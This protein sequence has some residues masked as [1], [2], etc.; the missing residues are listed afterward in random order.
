M[1]SWS[2]VWLKIADVLTQ[3][4]PF[5]AWKLYIFSVP[6]GIILHSPPDVIAT[7]IETWVQAWERLESKPRVDWSPVVFHHFFGP[8]KVHVPA[9]I[10]GWCH[11][12]ESRSPQPRSKLVLGKPWPWPK[13]GIT[14]VA[15][16]SG[17]GKPWYGT[18]WHHGPV[19]IAMTGCY[20]LRLYGRINRYVI[21]Q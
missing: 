6:R 15:E 10:R 1:S 7:N 17:P 2:C 13:L 3:T 11:P 21:D 16:H 20:P 9:P 8:W 4:G 19:F 12:M 18:G 5:V 14:E